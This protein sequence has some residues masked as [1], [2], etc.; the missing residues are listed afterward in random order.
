MLGSYR[1]SDV[2]FPL[3]QTFFTR[4]PMNDMKQPKPAMSAAIRDLEDRPPL[5]GISIIVIVAALIAT[6]LVWAH[7][8]KVDEVTRGDGKVVPS[9]KTQVIQSAEP[10]VVLEIVV[11]VGQRVKKGDILLRLD[12]TTSSSNLGE[13]EARVRALEAQVARLRIEH[14][15]DLATSYPCPPQIK[16]AA[17]Q[18][19]A[20]EESLM[21]VRRQNLQN[22]LNVF[23]ERVEQR[24]R[25]LNEARANITRFEESLAL[26]QSE[27]E[28][29]TPL[30]E[31]K[32]VAATDL[33][34]AQRQVNE[35]RG[36]LASARETMA[37]IEASLREANLQMNEQRLLF[38]QEALA[39][40]TQRLAELS[41][42]QETVR[43][44]TDRVNR[45]DIRSPVDGIVNT[46][47]INTLGAFVNAGTRIMDVV[48]VEEQLL[49]EARVRPSDI[50]FIRPGQPATVKVTAYDFSIYGGLGGNV[51]YISADSVID[52]NSKEAFYTVRVKTDEASLQRN[53][54]TF[55]IMPGMVTQ[56][57]IL[58]GKKSILDYIL[59]PI[60]KA[61]SEA[62]RER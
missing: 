36:Q 24:Q 40:L 5:I 38:R 15:G 58:T 42:V 2:R 19:C 12:D 61:Q 56:V 48:P 30:A 32:I 59:K 9:S 55:P 51:E 35:T 60:N 45:T 23:K 11:R 57:E 46:I 16:K 50:A 62:L 7:L 31:R 27:L 4:T 54:E 47:Y 39:E 52:E 53:G 25:E 13:S 21:G 3:T 6:F 20:N 28:L 22:R 10:G 49:I 17:P 37:R 33:I 14:E 41:V 43:G 44:A 1:Q 26:S 34:R 18:I 8:T 29:I